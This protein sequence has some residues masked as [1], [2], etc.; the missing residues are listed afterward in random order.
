MRKVKIEVSLEK[1]PEYSRASKAW[2]Q[3]A[4]TVQKILGEITHV[5]DRGMFLSIKKKLASDQNRPC[6]TLK[7]DLNRACNIAH[8]STLA[9]CKDLAGVR[10]KRTL[11]SRFSRERWHLCAEYQASLL[12]VILHEKGRLILYEGRFH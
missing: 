11:K 8:I 5:N 2:S 6:L 9:I 3:V 10:K 7:V 12:S 4:I 1:V